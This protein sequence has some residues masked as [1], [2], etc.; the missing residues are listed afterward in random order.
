[1]THP[2]YHK[3][4]KPRANAIT[5]LCTH[6]SAVRL[7]HGSRAQQGSAAAHLVC[8]E[9]LNQN[10]R[11][12]ISRIERKA[13]SRANHKRIRPCNG[14]ATSKSRIIRVCCTVIAICGSL[15]CAQETLPGRIKDFSLPEY[16]SPPNEN[17]IRAM[18]RGAEAELRPNMTIV[19]YQ[20]YAETFRETGERE[21]EIKAPVCH[22]D[23]ANRLAYS[24]EALETKT[25]D[26][27]LVVHGKG[28][29]WRR[30]DAI[31]IISNDV[32]CILKTISART[33]A[34]AAAAAM[35]GLLS[36]C[37][38]TNQPSQAE[39]AL[40]QR[41]ATEIFADHAEF[42][43]KSNE[44]RYSGNVRVVNPVLNVRCDRL[45]ARLP[46]DAGHIESII[47]EQN[48]EF[49]AVDGRG[50]RI[51]GTSQKAVYTWK[52]TD[53]IT[54]ELVELTGNPV[55]NTDQGTLAGDVIVFDRLTGRITATNP[56][57]TVSQPE[58]S[59]TNALQQTNLHTGAPP[60]TEPVADKARS[61]NAESSAAQ[62]QLHRHKP[63]SRP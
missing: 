53:N 51:R 21:L 2:P 40:S 56:R 44:A 32:H 55:L 35:G 63:E 25:G 57:M 46:A 42:D 43:L 62:E 60:V 19:I 4:A 1:M 17:R 48:V 54:N 8:A 11:P 49:D 47:A 36:I 29:L 41:P 61:T 10:T 39:S 13:H 12:G 33:V 6:S 7:R 15:A 20:L 45:T 34:P 30:D 18:L 14:V 5:R 31:L 22:Y 16:F 50:K 27:R 38:Q 3:S 28:F 37:G 26:G 52:V 23:S 9:Y 58:S 59:I 24:D